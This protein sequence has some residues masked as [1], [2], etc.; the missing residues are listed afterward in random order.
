MNTSKQ[1][2]VLL[3]AITVVSIATAGLTSTL[4]AQRITDVRVHQVAFSPSGKYIGVCCWQPD[5]GGRVSVWETETWQRVL[6]YKEGVGIG[7]V[8]FS[9][10]ETL[11]TIGHAG[12]ETPIFSLPSGELLRT[13]TGHEQ[14]VRAVAFTPDGKQIVT[15][16]D[17][18]TVAFWDVQTGEKL[19]S[20]EAAQRRL[21]DLVLTP[22]GKRIIVADWDSH[23]MRVFD[24]ETYEELFAS[25]RF[26]SITARVS[27]SKSGALIGVSVWDLKHRVYDANTYEL[28]Y[29]IKGGSDWIEFSP[30][31]NLIAFTASRS[32]C[33]IDVS[34]PDM[35]TAN[36]IQSLIRVFETEEDYATREEAMAELQALGS[37]C[38]P[39]LRAGMEAENAEVRWRCRT[40]RERCLSAD[41]ARRF[42]HTAEVECLSYSPDG[43]FLAAG[44]R[45]GEAVIWD[46]A[47]GI[48]VRRLKIRVI[49]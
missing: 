22:D 29:T 26:E 1:L 45:N 4:M 3:K 24:T 47:E 37:I 46:L 41:G 35:Q 18:T 34:T 16:S 7:R 19:A 31:E 20:F 6:T 10:D 39:Y 28:K 27:I 40:L 25:E 32:A 13:L 2:R 21:A 15:G 11:V 5:V 14:V 42:E 8:V 44:D 36:R 48:A 43:K 49:E 12:K 23:A 30:D 33:V 9:P 38:E 17:D